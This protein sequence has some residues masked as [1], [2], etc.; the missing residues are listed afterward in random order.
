MLELIFENNTIRWEGKTEVKLADIVSKAGTNAGLGNLRIGFGT[1]N[2][3]YI[4]GDTTAL[5]EVKDAADSY[6]GIYWD[7]SFPPKG[8]LTLALSENT[9]YTELTTS[10]DLNNPSFQNPVGNT[11]VIKGL[12]VKEGPVVL[13][14]GDDINGKDLYLQFEAG[15]YGVV[16]LIKVGTVKVK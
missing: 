10:I 11:V 14:P 4:S 15:G 16:D 5:L 1:F 3:G 6:T 9:L 13:Q 2:G 7:S 8:N 12:E